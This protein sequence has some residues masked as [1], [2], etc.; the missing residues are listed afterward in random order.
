MLGRCQARHLAAINPVLSA[1]V[2]DRLVTDIEIMRDAGN[3]ASLSEQVENLAP[4]LCR[5]AR[6]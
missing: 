5:I 2:V 3:A 6:I 1:P 4:E